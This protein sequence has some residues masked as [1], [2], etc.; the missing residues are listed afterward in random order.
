M[1]KVLKILLLL[2]NSYSVCTGQDV[3]VEKKFCSSQNGYKL[4]LRLQNSD[5]VLSSTTFY[6]LKGFTSLT[7]DIK[8]VIIEKLLWYKNDTSKCCLPVS[9]YVHN[10][11]EGCSGTPQSKYYN[12]QVDALF[13]IGRLCFSQLTDRYSC[14]PVL[15]DTEEKKEI[16][17]EPEKIKLVFEEYEKWY[18]ECKSKGKIGDY[19][20][21]N[22]GRYVW[23]G[24]RKSVVA[25]E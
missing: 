9:G 10:Y 12:I 13:M 21:F 7:D 16:N 24:G 20:P 23:Y 6:D 25:K 4:F 8:L 22:D 18:N 5:S 14:H 15:Y 11:N 17:S 3:T 1:N 2:I 19:F